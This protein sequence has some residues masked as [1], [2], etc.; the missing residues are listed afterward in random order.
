MKCMVAF[1]LNP[2]NFCTD[3]LCINYAGSY[4]SGHAAMWF[5]NL[6][7]EEGEQ[8]ALTNWEV[9]FREFEANF[10][11]QFPMFSAQHRL[12]RS[13]ME[14]AGHIMEH[15]SAFMMDAAAA[16]LQDNALQMLFYESLPRR[17]QVKITEQG[18]PEDFR[19][20]RVLARQIDR[21]YWEQQASSRPPQNRATTT[22]DTTQNKPA[23]ATTTTAPARP[24]AP[25][26]TTN[27]S[28]TPATA[29]R[30]GWSSLTQ[31]EKD[32]IKDHRRANG[33]CMYCGG[34]GHQ[35]LNCPVARRPHPAAA[36]ARAASAP[37]PAPAYAPPSPAPAATVTEVKE[38]PKNATAA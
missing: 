8:E 11:E 16:K 13:R 6:V 36:A 5:Q 21:I 33:L 14:S 29:P 1:R 25:G 35:A 15:E 38:E 22:T 31:E 20:L 19:K 10:G 26:H 17:L 34:A 18:R 12:F 24:A 28:S 9:F 2:T 7:A 3:S 23:P 30:K 4:M 32:R 37:P 27:A